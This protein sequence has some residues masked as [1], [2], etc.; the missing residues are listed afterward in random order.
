MFVFRIRR[1]GCPDEEIY[2]KLFQFIAEV[3]ND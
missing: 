3:N 1:H 2:I